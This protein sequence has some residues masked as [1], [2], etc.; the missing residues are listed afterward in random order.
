MATVQ[1]LSTPGCAGCAQTKALI[2]RV[3][4]EFPELDWEEVDLTEFP[5]LAARYGI[6][7]VPAVV[8]GGRLEFTGVPK[9]AALRE[10]VKALIEGR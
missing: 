8:I 10:K 1:I 4:Q 6:L 2:T 9:E 7:S 5:E 3:L